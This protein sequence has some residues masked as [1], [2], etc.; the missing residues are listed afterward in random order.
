MIVSIIR[1]PTIIENSAM[2]APITPPIGIAY[3]NS[4]INKF[5]NNIEIIDAIGNDPVI[6]V[7]DFGNKKIR[8]LGQDISQ[9]VAQINENSDIILVSIMFSQDWLYSKEIISKIKKKCKKSILIAGGEHIT[10]LPDYVM[11]TTPE[12]DICVL[13]EGE[14]ALYNL[15]QSYKNNNDYTYIP[16]TYVRKGKNFINNKVSPRIKEIDNIDL[17]DWD[18]IPL[19]NYFNAGEGFGVNYGGRSM[20][21]LASRGCP[22]QCTFCSNPFMWTTLW[23]AR[24][25]EDVLDEMENYINKYQITNFD[26]YD[27]TVVVK[28]KWIIEFCNLLIERQLNISWQLPSGTRSEAIDDEVAKL[29]YN[30]GCRNL[31]YA[32]ESGSIETLKIIKKKIKLDKMLASMK[33]CIN[34]NLNI[35]AN[36]MCGF[37]HEKWSH[38][39]ET[40]VFM[41]KMSFAGC[42]DVSVTQFSPYPGSELFEQLKKEGKIHF[43]NEYFNGLSYYSSMTNAQSFSNYLSNRDIII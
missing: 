33:S 13:G 35:K 30:S 9:I 4:V 8:L 29:L 11:E 42:H 43:D 1:V 41:I 32:P 20:P 2:T 34:N 27:L 31:S 12:I 21:M 19:E 17:P 15:L 22:Y 16:G 7:T 24:N 36:I 25:P 3:L 26:F 28:K 18:G 6:R 10:A 23:K 5:T 38:L 14:Q 37:P 39:F 40:L